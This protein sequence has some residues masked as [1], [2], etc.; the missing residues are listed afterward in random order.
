MVALA[1]VALWA[2]V[3][4]LVYLYVRNEPEQ[5]SQTRD[6]GVRVIQVQ[7]FIQPMAE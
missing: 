1:L 5:S 3:L 4:I 6:D 7:R 2:V